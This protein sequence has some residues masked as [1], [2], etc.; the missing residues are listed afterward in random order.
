[1]SANPATMLDTELKH[2]NI[3]P[4]S[5]EEFLGAWCRLVPI[6]RRFGFDVLFALVDK[7]RNL[8]TWAISHPGDLEAAA[9]AYQEDPERIELEFISNYVTGAETTKVS[10]LAIP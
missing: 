7:E 1:M 8:F 10:R 5:W 6:R 3:K 2:Y 9:K 4:D